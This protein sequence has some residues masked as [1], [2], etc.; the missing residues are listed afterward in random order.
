[1]AQAEILIVEDQRIIAEGIQNTLKRLGY[2][3]AGI[4]NSGE[5]AIT[6]VAITPLLKT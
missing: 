2:S 1:M 5:E 3:V 6:H 4:V